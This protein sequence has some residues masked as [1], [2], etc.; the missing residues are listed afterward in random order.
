[1]TVKCRSLLAAASKAASA[2]AKYAPNKT[3]RVEK[4]LVRLDF[5]ALETR[6]VAAS[7]SLTLRTANDSVRDIRKV[8]LNAVG[9]QIQ[10]VDGV[11][12]WQLSGPHLLLLWDEPFSNAAETRLVTIDYRI[13]DPVAGMY[14]YL[15]DSPADASHAH[16][17]TDNEPEKARY[18]LPCIDAP[19]LTSEVTF[20][21][22]TRKGMSALANGRLVSRT[23][24][25]AGSTVWVWSTENVR[26]PSYLT[27]IAVGDFLQVDHGEVNGFA[28][29]CSYLL[30]FKNARCVYCPAWNV[31]RGRPLA[32]LWKD[33]GNG[34]LARWKGWTC[35][36]LA[37]VLSNRISR[38]RGWRFALTSLLISLIFSHGESQ[39]GYLDRQVLL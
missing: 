36:S 3:V 24:T 39:L 19:A 23:D 33:K 38:D 7:H 37:K 2:T 21:I 25:D 15:P 18:W 12:S 28:D 9:L 35:L 20:E 16:V 26:L 5:T 27:C 6:S 32:Y 11:D 30:H 29:T 22:T 17:I 1:M 14:F 8:Q 4:S 34:L 10:K 13:V 31:S